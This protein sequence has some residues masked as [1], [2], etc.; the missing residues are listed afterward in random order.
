MVDHP[1]KFR[2][3]SLSAGIADAEAEH[4]VAACRTCQEFVDA[5]GAEQRALLETQLPADFARAIR[6]EA[7]RR[8][9]APARRVPWLRWASVLVPLAACGVLAFVWLGPETGSPTPSPARLSAAPESPGVSGTD[10][11]RLRGPDTMRAVVLR[12]GAQ[13]RLDGEIDGRPGDRIR[14]ELELA[15]AAKMTIGAW[16]DDRQ[17]IPLSESESLDAGRHFVDGSVVLDDEPTEGWLLAGP[18][19]EVDR[20]VRGQ[21]ELDASN[22]L[23]LRLRSPGSE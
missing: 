7:D 14:I 1:S 21:L 15:A 10:V 22:V 4:H 18:P 9:A 2:L 16:T 19:Q 11:I 6:L 20:I 8:Q 5:L 17:W 23:R 3:E 12:D 13:M